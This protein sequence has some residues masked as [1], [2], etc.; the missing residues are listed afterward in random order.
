MKK[1]K[2]IFCLALGLAFA[3][4][5]CG[6]TQVL[7]PDGGDPSDD[8]PPQGGTV[9]KPPVVEDDSEAWTLLSE[10]ERTLSSL[11][12]TDDFGRTVT[13]TGTEDGEKYVGLFFFLWNGSIGQPS[14]KIQDISNDYGGDYE[15]FKAAVESGA[16][17]AGDGATIPNDT[18]FWGKPIW[19]YYSQDDEWVVRK[20]IE[21]LTMAGVDFL[22]FDVTNFYYDTNLNAWGGLYE[23]AANV[24]LKVISEYRA[25][26]WDAPQAM[27]YTNSN[28][29]DAVKAIYKTFYSG[30]KFP[31]AFFAPHGK[32]MIV[33]TAASRAKLAAGAE[34]SE[35]KTV[36]EFFEFKNTVW[37]NDGNKEI[38]PDSFSWME[39]YS[40]FGTYVVNRGG[41]VNISVAQHTNTWMFSD[42]ARNFGRGYDYEKQQNVTENARKGT[43]Y[44]FLWDAVLGS[45]EKID[46][47]AITGWNEW[48]GGAFDHQGG[49]KC[50]PF[51][52]DTFNEEYSRDLEP[53]YN[54]YGDN[55]YLQ[56]A[57]NI[58]K[59]KYGAKYQ[60]VA[61]AVEEMDIANLLSPVWED[62]PMR[63]LDF[64]GECM[65]RRHRG[66]MSNKVLKDSTNRND[67]VRVIATHDE[68]NLYFRIETDADITK[69]TDG[70]TKWMN[71]M[72]STG[73]D[74]P[75]FG[76]R[77]VINRT[78]NGN[79]SG[80]YERMADGSY[81][82][83]GK[84]QV[85]YRSFVMQVSVPRSLFGLDEGTPAFAF[86]VCDNIAD[87]EDVLSYYNSGDAA[88]IGRWG[89]SYG[90]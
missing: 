52:V 72:L 47:V 76:Y 19:D 28:D 33:M 17:Q 35:D 59:F 62:L 43:N 49:K 21:M 1:I 73:P 44:Q 70:D 3:L 30:N 7:P 45:D 40:Q 50:A 51:T 55:F 87:P 48:I 71:I 11:C 46:T 75:L 57:Q 12:A 25:A 67:I 86:K 29:Y 66:W 18:I 84:A 61:K 31:D 8:P 5:G 60:N 79:D 74:G 65:E 38:D 80:V 32:P 89:Y 77:Y 39:K 82:E 90:F 56:T 83:I 4:A 10:E 85:Y 26:G 69:Y 34:G 16:I 23:N 81:R 53:C 22:F 63:Y 2:N 36:S 6:P 88:P 13:V 42:L 15:T 54:G 58:K 78:L 68:E 64:K 20:Q 9:E 14:M 27:F 41:M 24:V 37:P